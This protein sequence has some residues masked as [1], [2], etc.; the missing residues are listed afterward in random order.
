MSLYEL[1]NKYDIP[2][3]VQSTAKM[4]HRF[5]KISSAGICDVLCLQVARMLYCNLSHDGHSLRQKFLERLSKDM[6]PH[7]DLMEFAEENH[8]FAGET[9]V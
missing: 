8:E 6:R 1:A 9:D 5:I 2:S 7:L 3:L 4:I